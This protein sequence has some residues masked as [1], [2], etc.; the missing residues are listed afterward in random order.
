M[1]SS[2]QMAI[3]NNFHFYFSYSRNHTSWFWLFSPI[4]CKLL[5]TLILY[6]TVNNFA[7]GLQKFG[8]IFHTFQAAH[9]HAFKLQYQFISH[10]FNLDQ[11]Q[12]RLGVHRNERKPTDA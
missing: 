4:H 5:T 9:Q 8:C 10:R 2:L 1:M 12:C 7:N 6:I 3:L 11:I